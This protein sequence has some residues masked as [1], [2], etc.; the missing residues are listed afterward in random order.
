VTDRWSELTASI[1]TNGMT[2]LLEGIRSFD[3]VALAETVEA[4]ITEHRPDDPSPG[5]DQHLERMWVN[6]RAA[7]RLRRVS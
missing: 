7:E 2:R 1:A 6:V 3:D 5:V 4:F